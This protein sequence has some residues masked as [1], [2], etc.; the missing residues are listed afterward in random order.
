MLAVDISREPL[1]VAAA[2]CA[3]R[4]NIR[5]EPLDVLSQASRLAEMA[6]EAGVDVVFVDINGNRASAAV[7]PLV[8]V[9]QERLRPQVT[10][11]KSRELYKAAG[12]HRDACEGGGGGESALPEGARFWAE[13]LL[14]TLAYV[15]NTTTTT[16]NPTPMNPT[17]QL[18]TPPSN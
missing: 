8:R 11:V 12:K 7:A 3:H 16:M 15:Y 14:L 5:F 1:E 2:H 10:V 17:L 9:L 18:G 13:V 4:T 6:A